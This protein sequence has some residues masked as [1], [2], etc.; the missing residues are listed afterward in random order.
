MGDRRGSLLYLFECSLKHPS[1]AQHTTAL[2][3]WTACVLGQVLAPLWLAISPSHLT[4]EL[5]GQRTEL[6]TM[7]QV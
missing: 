3:W 2:T 1:H 4:D 5:L 6:C 7:H